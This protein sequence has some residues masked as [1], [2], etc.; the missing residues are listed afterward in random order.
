MQ[1]SN[2]IYSYNEQIWNLSE[3]NYLVDEVSKVF[4]FNEEEKQLFNKIE[5]LNIDWIF[6]ETSIKCMVN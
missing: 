1:N 5:V 4:K 2:T 6:K 3:W